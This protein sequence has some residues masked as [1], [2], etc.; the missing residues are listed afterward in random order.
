MELP[1]SK[2]HSSS[3]TR[4][5]D[6]PRQEGDRRFSVSDSQYFPVD[7]VKLSND[8]AD[9]RGRTSV[10]TCAHMTDEASI[11]GKNS[12]CDGMYRA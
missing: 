5:P 11:P 7:D 12:W 9:Q 4:V 8:T 6:V 3:K 10:E 2:T 1:M